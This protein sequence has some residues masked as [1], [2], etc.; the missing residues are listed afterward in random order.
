MINRELIEAVNEVTNR[1]LKEERKNLSDIYDSLD[2]L[3][4]AIRD[5][6]NTKKN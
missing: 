5:I 4:R 6:K 1:P 3:E 2:F